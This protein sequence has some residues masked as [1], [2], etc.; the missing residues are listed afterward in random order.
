VAG[1]DDVLLA[2][3][4]DTG[5]GQFLAEDLGEFFHAQLDFEDVAA[6]L[7]AGAGLALALRRGQRLA[8]LALALAGAAG[9]F[10]AVAELRQVDLRQGNAD[11]VLALLADQLAAADVLAQAGLHLAA[12]DLAEALM[13]AFDPLAHGSLSSEVGGQKSEVRHW[14][15]DL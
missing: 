3:R 12:N 7:V 13:I 10:L 15:P 2:A 14:F 1:G 9:A 6:G 11:Q 8:D 5:Q 4:L